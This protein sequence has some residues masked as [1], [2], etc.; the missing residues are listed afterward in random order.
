M[1]TIAII[2]GR[3]WHSS[4][5]GVENAVRQISKGIAG[6][7][8]AKV[9]VYGYNSESSSESITD[10]LKFINFGTKKPFGHSH[11]FQ[12]LTAV[13]HSI[14]LARVSHVFL[15]ASGPSIFTPLY[16]LLGVEVTACLRSVDSERN[17]W[18]KV[19]KMI[20][21]A[22]EYCAVKYSNYLSVNSMNMYKRFE[23]EANKILYTPNGVELSPD[24]DESVLERFDS[25]KPFILFA[26]RLDPVKRLH[27]LLEAYSKSGLNSKV[28]LVVAGGNCKDQQYEYQLKSRS[29]QGVVWLGHVK[30]EQ[31]NCLMREC[32]LFVLPSILEGMSNSLLMGMK[33]AKPCIVAGIPENTAL[34]DIHECIF[35]P[36]SSIELSEKLISFDDEALCMS[37]GSYLRERVE[38]E[39]SWGLTVDR[40]LSTVNK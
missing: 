34:V 21:R 25:R 31:V 29:P 20:L 26:A 27:V 23:N 38:S 3:G 4:Y 2:G 17:K 10:Y 33:H 7:N 37:A 13:L 40:L 12:V 6:K 19:S 9:I 32:K 28:N 18:G 36:D 35:E 16:R 11:H 15:F 1:K 22:G 30:T 8:C 14:F 5:G 24:Y 39:F